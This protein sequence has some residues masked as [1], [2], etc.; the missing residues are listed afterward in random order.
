MKTEFARERLAQTGVK[1]SVHRLAVMDYLIQH[2]VHPTVDAIYAALMP[3][4]PTLSKTTVYNTLKLL[5]SRHAIR[6][7][8]IDEKCVHYD[9]DLSVHGHFQCKKCGKIVDL[10]L[11]TIPAGVPVSNWQIDECQVYF[12]GYCEECQTA[13][14]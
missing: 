6:A 14:C 8:T 4:I 9:A 2:P 10:Q 11:N 1:P 12:R 3:H 5:E 7:I 13:V